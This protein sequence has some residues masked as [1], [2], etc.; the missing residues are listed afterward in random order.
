MDPLLQDFARRL[1]T[2]PAAPYF[3]QKVRAVVEA[4][5]EEHGLICK[6]DR[7]GNV[8]VAYQRG[9]SGRAL[10]LAAHMDHPGFEIIENLG[11]N[12]WR[13]RFRGGVGDSYFRAGVA[14]RFLPQQAK[15]KLVERLEA[16]KEFVLESK[17]RLDGDPTYA[18][19]E[20]EDFAVRKAQIHGRACDDLIGC[21]SILATMVELKQKKVSAHVLGVITR[22]EEV[23]FHGAL[24]VAEEKLLPSDALVISLETSREMPPVKMGQGVIVRVGDRSSI[25]DS[26]ATRF[27]SEIGS[28]LSKEDKTF[29]H[30][31]ALMSGGTCEGTAY[32]E[33]GYQT[34]A[35]CVAL[36]NY[37]NCGPRNQIRA[38]YVSLADAT[39]MV[40][41]LVSAAAQMKR[42]DELVVRLPGRLE[43]LAKEA[44]A[45][46]RRLR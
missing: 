39:G 45:E 13:A 18:V 6:R 8:L 36:G 29:R 37:H 31:R 33:Y 2:C 43:K 35:L 3:E 46:F 34:A 44:R 10:A 40:R 4:I 21:A 9:K 12:R 38:E 7:Y 5:C 26:E 19:W 24:M 22:S 42:F 32:Q 25:F 15:G 16:E 27:L 30:Q 17:Q 1:M 23:G 14:V 41:L 11:G 20:L 28:E